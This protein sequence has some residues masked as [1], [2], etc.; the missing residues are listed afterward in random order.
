MWIVFLSWSWLKELV[1]LSSVT[2]QAC[3][4]PAASDLRFFHLC[5]FSEM[6][7][8]LH[9][10][11]FGYLANNLIFSHL[12]PPLLQWAGLHCEGSES[13]SAG[14]VIHGCCFWTRLQSMQDPLVPGGLASY[15]QILLTPV[16]ISSSLYLHDVQC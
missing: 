12:G 2:L 8:N 5:C 3:L 10:F 9:Y 11:L 16:R 15:C 14:C 4:N 1:L 6:T 13:T 7:G